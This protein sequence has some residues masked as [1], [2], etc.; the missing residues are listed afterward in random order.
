MLITLT[1]CFNNEDIIFP[2]GV[3]LHFISFSPLINE[4]VMWKL[5]LCIYLDCTCLV[6]KNI[7][8]QKQK[9]QKCFAQHLILHFI[10]IYNHFKKKNASIC[11]SVSL[12]SMFGDPWLNR[13]IFFIFK[14]RTKVHTVNIK[15][16][17][18]F[19]LAWSVLRRHR[20]IN[21]SLTLR[22]MR[23]MFHYSKGWEV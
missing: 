7:F 17:S 21:V 8:C 12:N 5:L 13:N 19:M 22:F 2:R 11:I 10:C 3:R 9:L 16:V 1:T 20:V 15:Q 18:V 14:L 23:E 4:A 6:M